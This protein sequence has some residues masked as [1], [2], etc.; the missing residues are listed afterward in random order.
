MVTYRIRNTF[1]S[2]N[3]LYE[4]LE[5]TLNDFRI[6]IFPIEATQQ[7][8]L[9]ILAPK[10]LWRALAHVKAGNTSENL[11]NYIRQIIYY[12]YQEKEN[13][14]KGYNKIMNSI[15]LSNRMDTIFINS[16]NNKISNPHR[17][18]LRV[19]KHPILTDYYLIFWIK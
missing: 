17:L 4:G 8:G 2:V 7:K 6:E 9:K 11:L 14:K 15:K 19:I 16:E 3:T 1:D 18:I 13:T 10:R 12:L 5:L